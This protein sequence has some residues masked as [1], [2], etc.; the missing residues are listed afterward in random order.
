MLHRA[1]GRSHC[2]QP[3]LD[4]KRTCALVDRM[5][6]HVSTAFQISTKNANQNRFEHELQQYLFYFMVLFYRL[7]CTICVLTELLKSLTAFKRLTN[8]RGYPP[9]NKTK[10]KKRKRVMQNNYFN[11]VGN[12][13]LP[14]LEKGSQT[15]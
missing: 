9:P 11:L 1:R 4:L 3:K 7:N 15:F 13:L 12:I 2:A 14:S 6:S 8:Q 10:G 5:L